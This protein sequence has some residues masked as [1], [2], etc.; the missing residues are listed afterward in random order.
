MK[1]EKISE[2]QIRCTLTK[3]DLADRHIGLKDLAYGAPQTRE[4]FQ[5]MMEQAF[6]QFGFEAEDIPLMIEATPLSSESLVLLITKVPDPDEL[7][8]RFSRFTAARGPASPEEDTSPSPVADEILSAF[9]RLHQMFKGAAGGPGPADGPSSPEEE[10][11]QMQAKEAEEALSRIFSFHTL[12]EV[13]RMSAVLFPFYQGTNSL[14]KDEKQGRYYLIAEKSSHTPKE[15]NKFCN[16][17]SEYAEPVPSGTAAK[18]SILEHCETVIA[19][20]AIR[21]LSRM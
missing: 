17:M 21:I 12:E 19:E 7:D 18:E 2:N 14:Y 3:K 13:I 10:A 16:M 9:D 5:E 15:F 20:D 4:L 1:I 8:T 11:R 6:A